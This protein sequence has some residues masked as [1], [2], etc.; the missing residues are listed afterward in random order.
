[1]IKDAG[2]E[3]SLTTTED[4]TGWQGL[5][6]GLLIGGLISPVL[7]GKSFASSV[8]KQGASDAFTART[9]ARASADSSRKLRSGGEG[10][11]VGTDR[12]SATRSRHRCGEG[13][14]DR[15]LWRPWEHRD[16]GDL[17]APSRRCQNPDNSNTDELSFG[18]G[19]GVGVTD[20]RYSRPWWA[21][22]S[23]ASR[24]FLAPSLSRMLATWLEAVL[25][26]M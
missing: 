24:R 5:G 4:K 7:P 2:V 12:A 15:L 16:A 17:H 19:E 20:S 21:A 22:R 11:R 25:V 1:M 10:A 23:A 18:G 14:S 26:L 6:C 3:V 8:L 9:A 13:L